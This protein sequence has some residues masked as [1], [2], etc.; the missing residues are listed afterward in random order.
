MDDAALAAA[1]G[2]VAASGAVL[3]EEAKTL[4]VPANASGP[5]GNASDV[6]LAA[7]SDTVSVTVADGKELS[8]PLGS[9]FLALLRPD[10]SYMKYRGA[11]RKLGVDPIKVT[12]R[13][14]VASYFGGDAAA[15]LKARSRIR[16]RW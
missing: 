15:A 16:S 3:D 13:A 9:F 4:T 14:A 7:A 11:C 1:P 8:Y 2:G 12:E 10:E 5:L 6:T